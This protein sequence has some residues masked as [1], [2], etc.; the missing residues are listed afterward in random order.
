M[1]PDPKPFATAGKTTAIEPA[2][3]PASVAGAE[4][5]ILVAIGTRL[6]DLR[7]QRGMT[8]DGLAQQTGFTKS[9]LSKIENSRKVPPIASLIRISKALDTDLSNLFD[10]AD[11]SRPAERKISL[12]RFD[13]R[14]SAVAGGT[15]FGYDYQSLIRGAFKRQMEPFIA[16]FPNSISGDV[17]FEHEGEELI[18]VVSGR[19]RFTVG[20]EVFLLQ[21][22]D[23]LFFDAAIPHRG[24][25]VAGDAKA[26][27]IVVGPSAA[28]EGD[29]NRG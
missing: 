17:R 22:G 1:K 28:G 21:T 13:D 18:F 6:R 8:L 3:R 2:E 5:R 7:R 19:V 15:S 20:D 12:V 16:T 14:R 4:E 25:S 27:I 10:G 9:Y 23:S 29:R 26:L 24:E 11:G